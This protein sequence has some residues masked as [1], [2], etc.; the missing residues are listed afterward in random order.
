MKT[1]AIISV[2]Y[3]NHEVKSMPILLED[4][5][6]STKLVKLLSETGFNGMNILKYPISETG[7]VLFHKHQLDESILKLD[8]VNEN[9]IN[10][11][12]RAG[13]K[14]EEKVQLIKG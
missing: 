7:L 13:R 3:R 9:D 11:K 5:T 2:T 6:E 1:Y 4:N 14:K 10:P 8:I 12:K